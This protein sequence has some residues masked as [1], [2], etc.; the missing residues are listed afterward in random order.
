MR[1]TF[2]QPPEQ[3]C[4]PCCNPVKSPQADTDSKIE[5]RIW[6]AELTFKAA[7]NPVL[8]AVDNTIR[9]PVTTYQ[10]TRIKSVNWVHTGVYE[11]N[12]AEC[13]LQDG[14]IMTFTAPIDPLSIKNH[15]MRI[16]DRDDESE[17]LT[18]DI[19][20]VWLCDEHRV[21]HASM[22]VLQSQ[23]EVI[24]D[25]QIKIRVKPTRLTPPQRVLFHFRADFVL[26]KCC[27]PI[28]GNHFGGL[29]PF[30]GWEHGSQT[31]PQQF[32]RLMAEHK[33]RFRLPT[34][35]DSWRSYHR[36]TSVMVCRVVT[37]R[38]VL[39]GSWWLLVQV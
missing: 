30:G 15:D 1:L 19:V 33:S 13:L 31:H 32:H 22:Q 3:T 21:G 16:Y 24:S 14:L 7:P 5:C 26:D 28:D 35:C 29:V 4:D 20:E 25:T 9:R 38:V 27:R 17:I 18:N 6:L 12:L 23:I 36:P 34:S 2:E 11:E 37:F 10:P 39:R 8:C